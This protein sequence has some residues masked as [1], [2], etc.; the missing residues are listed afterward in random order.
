MQAFRRTI[1]ENEEQIRKEMTEKYSA[2]MKA[3]KKQADALETAMQSGNAEQIAN[4]L[5][6]FMEKKD[7]AE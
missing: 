6:A 2:D 3:V 5:K 4:T 1:N 7:K